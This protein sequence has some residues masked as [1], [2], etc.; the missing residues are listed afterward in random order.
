MNRRKKWTFCLLFISLLVTSGC[1]ARELNQLAISIGI[2]I[3]KVDDGY[4][5]TE[6]ILNP[7]SIAAAK[8]VDEPAVILFTQKS[9][10]IA[11]AIRR[12]SE[13]S[14][15]EVY[16]SHVRIVVFGEKMARDG[17]QDILEF[18]SRNSEFRSDFYFI[19]AKNTTAKEILTVLTRPE[20][21]PGMQMFNTLELSEK[22]WSPA[23][24]VR[25]FELI[26]TLISDGKSPVLTGIEITGEEVTTTNIDALKPSDL[27]NTLKVSGIG[28]FNKDKLSGWLNED[29]SKGY[30]Y[31]TN[32]VKSTVGYVDYPGGRVTYKKTNS[33][34]SVTA[35][36]KKGKPY[37]AVKIKTEADIEAIQGELDMLDENNEAMVAGLIQDKTRDYCIKAIQKVQKEYKSDIFGFG[38]VI[39]RMDPKYWEQ[40]KGH[41]SEIFSDL[42]VQVSVKV[43][44]N[45]LGQVSKSYFV[46]E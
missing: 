22:I 21:I 46:K 41:W 39:H 38:E 19:V 28:V 27:K 13:T 10:D 3:D 1:S 5:V 9:R 30:N 2:G 32:N 36:V 7:K 25:I 20:S 35:I 8:T 12:M 40:V 37:I 16:H 23:K 17:I 4:E 34:T 44:I 45:R 29:E 15:R 43:K 6:Q 11:E 31:L 24:S 18:M 33:D 42:P 14:P 26:N